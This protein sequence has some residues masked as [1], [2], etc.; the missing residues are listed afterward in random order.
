MMDCEKGLLSYCQK[1]VI[2]G[3]FNYVLSK[4][5]Q[6]KFL[7][8][9]MS[10]FHLYELVQSP[11]RV[12][13]TSSSQLDFILTNSPSHFQNTAAVLFGD[14][15]HHVIVSFYCARG[16][17]QSC[18]HK[19]VYSQQYHKLGSELLDSILLDD[20]WSIVFDVDNVNVC[21]EAF[22]LVVQHFFDVLLPVRKLQV[23]LCSNPW[24]SDSAILLL[25]RGEIGYIVRH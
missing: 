1:L 24:S 6:T 11:N 7:H 12:T 14:N 25:D 21:A 18:D 4:S 17:C 16:I 3:D 9:F 19:I 2:L 15:D 13:A 5:Q 10:Q 23:K 22:T 8:S 20:S